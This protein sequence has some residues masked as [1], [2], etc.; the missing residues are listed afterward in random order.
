M[1]LSES[2]AS[3]DPGAVQLIALCPACHEVKHIGLAGVRGRGPE[4]LARL[5]AVNG[6]TEAQAKEHETEE[7]ALWEC[8]SEYEW[9]TDLSGLDQYNGRPA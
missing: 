5:A 9:T 2:G 4:A 3:M 8:R 7:R 1:I 6:W